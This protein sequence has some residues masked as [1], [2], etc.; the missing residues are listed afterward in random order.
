V[1]RLALIPLAAVLL[2]GCSNPVTSFVGTWNSALPATASQD[3]Q[4]AQMMKELAKL[5]T[6]QVNPDK[7]FERTVFGIAMKGT[8]T[9]ADKTATFSILTVA[10][11]DV[12]NSP[13]AI[14]VAVFFGT[15]S[16]DG[17]T[18]TLTYQNGVGPPSTFVRAGS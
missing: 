14:G 8:Y 3:P 1:S 2:A 4:A 7:S 9:V 12:S 10:G 11:R 5:N 6:L 16:A 18:L 17:K 13:S 15:L